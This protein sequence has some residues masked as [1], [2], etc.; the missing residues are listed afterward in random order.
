MNKYQII[1]RKVILEARK[2]ENGR[3]NHTKALWHI[4]KKESEL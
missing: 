1:Y 4:I 3:I 2:K